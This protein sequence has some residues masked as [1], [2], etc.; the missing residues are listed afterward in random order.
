MYFLVVGCIMAAGFYTDWF[1]SAISP[2]TTLGPLAFV[3]SVSL[4]VEG[5]ADRKRHRSDDLTNNAP[6]IILRRAVEIDQDE[7]AARDPQ[8]LG[9]KDVIVSLTKSYVQTSNSRA[10]RTPVAADTGPSKIVKIG[11]QRIRRMDIRQGHLILVKNREMIP[12]DMVLLASSGDRGSAYIETSSIDGETN[13]KLRTS[14][15]LPQKVLK[16][17]RLSPRI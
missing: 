1:E 6:C 16:H 10:P 3:V 12:A 15:H 13:L 8:I 2:W 9:G 14:P 11:F 17:L 4:L 7:G 5:A